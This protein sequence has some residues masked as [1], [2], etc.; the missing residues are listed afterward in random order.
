M[1]PYQSV[2]ERTLRGAVPG[3]QVGQEAQVASI[4]ESDVDQIIAQRAMAAGTIANL[5][6]YRVERLRDAA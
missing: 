3:V 6:A 5:R 4:G 2:R 1:F